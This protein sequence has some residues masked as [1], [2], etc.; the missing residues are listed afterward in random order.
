LTC[1]LDGTTCVWDVKEKKLLKQY[2]CHEG[3]Q[4]RAI[5]CPTLKVPFADCSLDVDWLDDSTFVSCG[6]DMLIRVIQLG[7]KG[8]IMTLS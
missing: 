1:S 3:C 4:S 2:R 7:E 6:A 5:F 8:E